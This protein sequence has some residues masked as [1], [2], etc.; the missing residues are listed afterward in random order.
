MLSHRTIKIDENGR[1]RDYLGNHTSAFLGGTHQ[2]DKGKRL[3]SCNRTSCQRP[4]AVGLH[5]NGKWYCRSCTYEI[6]A[7]NA[8]APDYWTPIRIDS[9]AERE[10]V[11]KVVLEN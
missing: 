1:P 9:E 8:G 2:P 7:A 11:N 5:S 10:Y 3:G 4:G 6:N